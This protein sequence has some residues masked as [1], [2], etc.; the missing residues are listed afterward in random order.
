LGGRKNIDVFYN[1]DDWYSRFSMFL[2]KSHSFSIKQKIPWGFCYVLKKK[3]S[4]R[5]SVG[6]WIEQVSNSNSR[7]LMTRCRQDL[8]TLISMLSYSLSKRAF[9]LLSWDSCWFYSLFE[10]VECTIQIILNGPHFSMVVESRL[11]KTKIFRKSFFPLEIRQ[12]RVN[13]VLSLLELV[14]KFI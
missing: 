8:L 6:I 13:H 12:K 5:P 7:G 4:I 10:K 9:Q 3:K 11:H 2:C 14:M 1:Y